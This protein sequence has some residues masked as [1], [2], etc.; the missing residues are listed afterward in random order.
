MKKI[1]RLR[2]QAA[3]LCYQMLYEDTTVY[4]AGMLN[5]NGYLADE[6]GDAITVDMKYCFWHYIIIVLALI[7][8]TLLLFFRDKRKNQLLTVAIVTIL[9]LILIIAGWCKWDVLFAILAEVIMAVFIILS[10][11]KQKDVELE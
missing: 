4:L 9:M 3:D 10:K 8:I 6:N 7:G 5:E 1:R 11:N 2:L